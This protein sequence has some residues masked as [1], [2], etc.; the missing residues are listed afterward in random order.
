MILNAIQH[1][2]QT[3]IR[4]QFIVAYHSGECNYLDCSGKQLGRQKAKK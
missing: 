4:F 1:L 2:F 3:R